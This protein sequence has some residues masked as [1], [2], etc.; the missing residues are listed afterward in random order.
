ML[1]GECLHSHLVKGMVETVC[2]GDVVVPIPTSEVSI[3]SQA[4]KTF[5]AWPKYFVRITPHIES[6]VYP[7][8]LLHI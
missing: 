6:L 8:I 4:L 3:V 1:H 7:L 5:I 2:C